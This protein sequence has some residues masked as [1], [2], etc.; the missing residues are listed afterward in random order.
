MLHL[1]LMYNRTIHNHCIVGINLNQYL[2]SAATS[3]E[4]YAAGGQPAADVAA[5]DADP[6]G[7]RLELQI[8]KPLL[9]PGEQRRLGF[10]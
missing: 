2:L 1:S 7:Q 3:A 6:D 5:S 10:V 8:R 4:W 9:Q